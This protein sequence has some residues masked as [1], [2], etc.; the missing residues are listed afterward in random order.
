MM[1]SM[2]GVAVVPG[3][4][5][6]LLLQLASLDHLLRRKVLRH[7]IF[8]YTR[9]AEFVGPTIHHRFARPKII[10]GRRR[11]DAPF[12]CGGAPGVAFRRLFSAKKAPKKIDKEQS[13]GMKTK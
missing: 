9:H 5:I 4:V 7:E 10:R 1:S 13:L 8:G 12:E 2:S 3:M 11:R 6:L